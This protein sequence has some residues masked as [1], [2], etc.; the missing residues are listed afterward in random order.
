MAFVNTNHNSFNIA[1]SSQC[2]AVVVI[3]T[4]ECRAYNQIRSQLLYNRIF[5]SVFVQMYPFLDIL[6]ALISVLYDPVKFGRF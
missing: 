1:C 6:F 5:A 4:N 2:T 3:K